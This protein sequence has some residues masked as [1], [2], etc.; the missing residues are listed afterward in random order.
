MAG[1]DGHGTVGDMGNSLMD[2]EER[3]RTGSSSTGKKQGQGMR[4]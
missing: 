1:T 4:R 2:D 3:A